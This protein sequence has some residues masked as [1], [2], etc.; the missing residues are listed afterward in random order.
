MKTDQ[1]HNN[2]DKSKVLALIP[3]EHRLP[4]LL[5]LAIEAVFVGLAFGSDSTVK[6]VAI[7]GIVIVACVFLVRFF[8]KNNGSEAKQIAK[9]Q[10]KDEMFSNSLAV[11]RDILAKSNATDARLW[12]F[13]QTLL[14]AFKSQSRRFRDFQLTIVSGLYQ[15][16]LLRMGLP[17]DLILNGFLK[18]RMDDPY[19]IRTAYD[20]TLIFVVI[21]D[22]ISKTSLSKLV[23][24]SKLLLSN[25][26]NIPL[27]GHFD[28]WDTWLFV[29]SDKID[30]DLKETDVE[31]HQ[32]Y[33]NLFLFT[34]SGD[35]IRKC[36]H[37]WMDQVLNN[38]RLVLRPR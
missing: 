32:P 7:L 6:I 31:L 37:K 34:F 12:S 9:A 13:T 25:G 30:H 29:V 10:S 19:M 27:T 22:S 16:E 1:D 11:A 33:V 14:N 38:F 23:S 15:E 18:M 4:G 3:K 21:P 28:P 20:A 5:F 8:P 35:A 24:K 26:I 17:F 2:R 36:P